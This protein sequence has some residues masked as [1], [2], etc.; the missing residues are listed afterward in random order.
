VEGLDHGDQPIPLASRIGDLVWSGGVA[1]FVPGSHSCPESL[2]DEAVQMFAN[3][4]AAIT[5]AGG[6]PDDI[7]RMTFFVRDRAL[8]R[9][10]INPPWVEMFPDEASRPAR[11]TVLA[12]LPPSMR[13]QCEFV[14]VITDRSSG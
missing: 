2:G 14:A 9:P 11:H 5:S 6:T 7:I 3:V 13:V 8:A 10:A 12:E 4:A 1:G